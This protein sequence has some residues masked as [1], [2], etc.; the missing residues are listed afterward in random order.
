[1]I[2]QWTN[3]LIDP[4]RI[5]LNHA[6]IQFITGWYNHGWQLV[7]CHDANLLLQ[8][9]EFPNNLHDAA[10]L[11]V[12]LRAFSDGVTRC[13]EHLKRSSQLDEEMPHATSAQIRAICRKYRERHF[14][15]RIKAT[16][17]VNVGVSKYRHIN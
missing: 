13:W 11:R 6:I 12:A 4:R 17:R 9:A 5:A 14:E 10:R 7:P 3:P 1:M 8:F 2:K 16:C 15:N